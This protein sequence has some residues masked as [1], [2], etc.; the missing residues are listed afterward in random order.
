MTVGYFFFIIDL[1]DR[2]TENEGRTEGVRDLYLGLTVHIVT[3]VWTGPGRSKE[4]ETPFQYSTW[5]AR[6]QSFEPSSAVFPGMLAGKWIRTRA[7]T[8]H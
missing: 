5:V 4:P 3:I 2:T 1:K 8:L 7:A 6:V